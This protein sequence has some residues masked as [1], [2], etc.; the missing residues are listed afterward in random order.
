[1]STEPKL[2]PYGSQTVGPY[3]RIGF[4]YLLDRTPE[5][6]NPE[7]TIEIRGRVIDRDGDPVPDALLE[8]WSSDGGRLPNSSNADETGFPDGFRR[9]PTDDAWKLRGLHAPARW[10]PERK[11]EVRRRRTCWF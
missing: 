1:M 7:A 9:A 8:F 11:T 6:A 5:L 4:D 10:H 3:F 2:T